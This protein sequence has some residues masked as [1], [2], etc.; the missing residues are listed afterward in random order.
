MTGQRWQITNLATDEVVSDA[1]RSFA[2]AE[3]ALDEVAAEYP[4]NGLVIERMR[5]ECCG[6]PAT[7]LLAGPHTGVALCDACPDEVAPVIAA[8]RA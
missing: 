4:L 5:C 1:H 2:D 3:E 7:R 6:A 8:V